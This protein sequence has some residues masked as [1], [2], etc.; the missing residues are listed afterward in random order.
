MVPRSVS[1][2]ISIPPPADETAGEG[3]FMQFGY[4]EQQVFQ[5]LMSGLSNQ[6][7]SCILGIDK[8]GVKGHMRDILAKLKSASPVAH[9]AL[10]STGAP[11]MM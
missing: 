11:T 1:Y 5:M 7:I 10:L 2:G 3:D 8:D 9:P 6:Q 4:R